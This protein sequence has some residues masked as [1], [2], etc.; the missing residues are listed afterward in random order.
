MSWIGRDARISGVTGMANEDRQGQR[1][2]FLRNEVKMP[3]NGSEREFTPYTAEMVAPLVN[4][5][6]AHLEEKVEKLKSLKGS[7]PEIATVTGKTSEVFGDLGVLWL[8]QHNQVLQATPL[9]VI[10]QGRSDEVL[11]L[12]GQIE[13]SVYI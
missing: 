2:T 1:L 6:I 3:L 12:L 10:S 7:S 5:T 13:Y 4:H 11:T 9:D 8:V